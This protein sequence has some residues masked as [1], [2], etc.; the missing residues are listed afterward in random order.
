MRSRLPRILRRFVTWL[1]GVPPPEELEG[2][3]Q[4]AAERDRNKTG[5]VEAADRANSTGMRPGSGPQ[6]LGGL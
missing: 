1:L 2:H 6:D 4:L 3:R 5:A